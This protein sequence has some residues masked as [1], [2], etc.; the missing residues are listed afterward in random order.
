ME[1]IQPSRPIGEEEACSMNLDLSIK[2]ARVCV[3]KG[4]LALSPNQL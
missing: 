4:A 1:S 3:F 2:Q